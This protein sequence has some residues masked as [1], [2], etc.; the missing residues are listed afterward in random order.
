MTALKSLYHIP[1]F[2]TLNEE[3][4][5]FCF[6]LKKYDKNEDNEACLNMI[7]KLISNGLNLSVSNTYIV[8][9]QDKE[10]IQLPKNAQN[11][12]LMDLLPKQVCLNIKPALNKLLEIN[13]KKI[14]YTF[15]AIDVLNDSQKKKAMWNEII[16]IK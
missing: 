4:N 16:K 12:I 3:A 1:P 13:N 7:E 9:I 14:I 8:Q 15:N 2:L 5:G 11:I 10:T 6:V